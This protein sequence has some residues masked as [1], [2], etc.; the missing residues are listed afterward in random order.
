MSDVISISQH[1]MQLR[2]LHEGWKAYAAQLNETIRCQQIVLDQ[3]AA[4]LG[5]EVGDVEGIG[6][7]IEDLVEHNEYLAGLA[8]SYSKDAERLKEALC[9]CRH[10]ASYLIGGIKAMQGQLAKVREIAK[11]ALAGGEEV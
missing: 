1:E 2:D 11:E 8:K 5:V 4:A 6:H 9:R 7:A 10:Q 3:I